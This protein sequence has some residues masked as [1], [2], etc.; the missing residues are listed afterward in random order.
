MWVFMEI[1]LDRKYQ[2]KG[3]ARES[4]FFLSNLDLSLN[5]I[6]ILTV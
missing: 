4:I 5:Y 6:D 2:R 3:R 1:P